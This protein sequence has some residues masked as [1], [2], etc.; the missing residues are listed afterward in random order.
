[1]EYDALHLSV[2]PTQADML[3]AELAEVGFESFTQTP[4]G[5][6]AFAP[7]NQWDEGALASLLDRYQARLVAQERIPPQNWNAVWEAQ[8]DP[9]V[10][11]GQLYLRAPFH[12]AADYPH[13]LIVQP[14][15]AF[16]TGHHPTTYLMLAAQLGGVSGE[17][18][19]DVGCGTGILSVWA[20]RLGAGRITAFDTDAWA[21]E[22]THE[23]LKINGCTR[24]D[25]HQGDIYSVPLQK[26]YDVVLANINRHIVLAQVADYADA[27]RAGGQ[28]LTSGF[29]VQDA[30]DVQAAAERAGLRLEQQTTRADWACLSFVK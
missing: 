29:Y 25:V 24:V 23:H 26:P 3:M 4:E 9:V 6:Q 2:A 20:E 14:R 27:L 15:M 28:L 1:M 10:V 30:A 21:V 11:E 5:L 16:G 19:L 17:A 13:T 12:P 7:A 22:N 18:V 8:F